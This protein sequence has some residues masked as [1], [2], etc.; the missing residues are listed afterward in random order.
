MAPIAVHCVEAQALHEGLI[1]VQVSFALHVG[2][3]GL[4]FGSQLRHLR[5]SPRKLSDE[6]A[7][8]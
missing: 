2:H 3:E 6:S 1:N 8:Y 4:S 7:D 5:K